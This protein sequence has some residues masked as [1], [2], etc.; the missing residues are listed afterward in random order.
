MTEEGQLLPFQTLMNRARKRV[1]ES[2]VSV[3]VR[4]HLFD[5]MQLNGVSL[6]TQ[7]FRFV[8]PPL[9]V[10]FAPLPPPSTTTV[11]HDLIAPLSLCVCVCVCVCVCM[12]VCVRVRVRV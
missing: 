10:S 12:Y 9:Q 5:M 3:R 7:P 11:F 2:R 6:L 8:Q 4:V 1:D